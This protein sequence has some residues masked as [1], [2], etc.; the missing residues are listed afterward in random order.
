MKRRGFVWVAVLSP[1]AILTGCALEGQ[2]ADPLA[3]FQGNWILDKSFGVT[4]PQEFSLT[5]QAARDQLTIHSH[6]KR[7][8][9]GRYG[10]TL[11]GITT[12]EFVLNSNGR[13]QAAQVGPFV[14]HYTSSLENRSIVTRWSTSEYMGSSFHG[15]WTRTL[16]KDGSTL[17]LDIGAASSSG[18]VSRARLIFK[19]R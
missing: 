2:A 12:P 10:L 15:T 1:A 6:W 11:I 19:R 16:S 5:I 13:E 4:P 8:E 14:V 18:D 3:A 7:P 9:D 17:T